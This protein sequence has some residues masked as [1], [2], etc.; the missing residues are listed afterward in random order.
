MIRHYNHENINFKEEGMAVHSRILAF[1]ILLTE[2]PGGL[3]S[4]V[5]QSVGQDWATKHSRAQC[6]FA[7]RNFRSVECILLLINFAL[8][9]GRQL[10]GMGLAPKVYVPL[11]ASWLRFW[12]AKGSPS[13]LL[14]TVVKKTF[15]NN[16]SF[17]KVPSLIGWMTPR[18]FSS[19]L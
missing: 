16:V 18:S 7:R 9:V 14:S 15:K 17:N 12:G 3:Q 4:M 11:P 19:C 5:L 1:K 13:L 10:T 2:E 8:P 6:Y